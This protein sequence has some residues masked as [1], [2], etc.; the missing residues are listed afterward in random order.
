MLVHGND[1]HI[2]SDRNGIEQSKELDIEPR[3]KMCKFRGEELHRRGRPN[4]SRGC[5]MC[6]RPSALVRFATCAS[7]ISAALT[8]PDFPQLLHFMGSFFEF[9]V[10]LLFC[11]PHHIYPT[12]HFLYRYCLRLKKNKPL[13]QRV[14]R[15]V[16]SKHHRRAVA[17]RCPLS[18]W[19]TGRS[20]FISQDVAFEE[21]QLCFDI[22]SKVPVP[23][24]QIALDV[25]RH[26]SLVQAA[27]HSPS[28][29]C[30]T[31]V[32]GCCLHKIESV[33]KFSPEI[34]MLWTQ[35]KTQLISDEV[36]TVVS[37]SD[38]Q[39]KYF[40]AHRLNTLMRTLNFEFRD[41]RLDALKS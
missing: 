25:R 28:Q 21:R 24:A 41:A 16:V 20:S 15:E 10:Y 29:L 22:N 32:S 38:A 14:T 8:R 7:L 23:Q 13:V 5:P 27:I 11:R 17:A 6:T 34:W 31:S 33:H 18:C 37:W 39:T 4:C 3:L 2:V 12:R 26:T 36:N 19:Q 35:K 1:C 9:S 40:S 30:T